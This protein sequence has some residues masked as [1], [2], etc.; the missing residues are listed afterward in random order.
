[1]LGLGDFENRSVPT[2]VRSLAGVAIRQVSCG[3]DHTALL[4]EDGT[5]YT[6]GR[7]DG[8]F[9]QWR[10]VCPLTQALRPVVWAVIGCPER[11]RFCLGSCRGAHES[12]ALSGS[13]RGTWGQTG[14]S[15]RDNTCLPQQVAA[16]AGQRIV[17]ASAR[18]AQL[19]RNTACGCRAVLAAEPTQL[20]GCFTGCCAGC[21]GRAAH[22]GP[23]RQQHA[24]GIWKQ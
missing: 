11:A 19:C 14:H 9:K 15:H 4:A 21:R 24:V 12:I 10:G 3:D 17:Q 23:C 7:W 6:M 2:L 18:T 22:T 16:L 8:M 1:M 13:C 20:L 5:V